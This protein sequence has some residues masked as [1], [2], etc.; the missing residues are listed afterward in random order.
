MKRLLDWMCRYLHGEPMLPIH[1]KY[2]CRK[3]LR[4]HPCHWEIPQHS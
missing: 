3:C 1:G 2:V 4:E